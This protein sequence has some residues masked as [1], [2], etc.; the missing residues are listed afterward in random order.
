VNVSDA[1]WRGLAIR[2][3]QDMQSEK[4]AVAQKED[5]AS[6]TKSAVAPLALEGRGV[7]ASQLLRAPN[8]DDHPRIRNTRTKKTVVEEMKGNMHCHEKWQ[9]KWIRK[10]ISSTFNAF[11]IANRISFSSDCGFGSVVFLLHKSV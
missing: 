4:D 10:K 1:P 7:V 11:Q 8:P 6:D 9:M 5:T 2:T 3:N